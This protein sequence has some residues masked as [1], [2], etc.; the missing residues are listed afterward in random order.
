MRVN[1]NESD[2]SKT[3]YTT[4]KEARDVII[5]CKRSSS[6]NKIPRRVYYC[7]ECRGFHV[8]SQKNV[9]SKRKFR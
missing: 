4:E 3:T 7:K 9:T 5:K 6:K 8:T 2:C 1:R